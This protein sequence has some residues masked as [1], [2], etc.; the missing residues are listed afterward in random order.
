M[1]WVVSFE[2]LTEHSWK[3]LGKLLFKEED[4]AA[5]CLETANAELSKSNPSRLKTESFVLASAQNQGV[6]IIYPDKF[7]AFR[8]LKFKGEEDIDCM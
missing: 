5:S 7:L 4:K 1:H 3:W 6:I 8:I 2:G